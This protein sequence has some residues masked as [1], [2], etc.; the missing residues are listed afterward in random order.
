M[1]IFSLRAVTTTNT[2]NKLR[3]TCKKLKQQVLEK[4][5]A[6][7]RHAKRQPA[8]TDQE[9]LSKTEETRMEVEDPTYLAKVREYKTS[10]RWA[11][12]RRKVGRPPY[13]EGF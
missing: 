6:V 3:S 2:T 7:I 10:G 8:Q 5:R 9:L 13:D 4:T 1:A 12:N 11:A